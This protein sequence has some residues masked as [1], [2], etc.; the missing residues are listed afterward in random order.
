MADREG[1]AGRQGCF[2]LSCFG[3]LGAL[4]LFVIAAGG[5]A[6]LA[7]LMGPPPQE[8]V[9]PGIARRLPGP[10]Q[11]SGSV[12][13]DRGAGFPAG[14][15]RPP[16]PG[17]GRIVLDLSGGEFEVRPGEPG[18]PVRVD[19]RYN[20]GAFEIVE[21]LEPGDD[22]A[23]WTY[24]L[25]FRRHVSWMR[26]L[27]GDQH[28]VNHVRITLPRGVPF[29]LEGDVNVG[30]SRWELGGLW[31]LGANLQ[32]GTGEHTLGFAEPTTEP[33][34]RFELDSRMGTFVIE[35]LGNASPAKVMIRGSMGEMNLDLRGPWRN[36]T[37]VVGRWRMGAFSVRVPQDVRI[38]SDGATVFMGGADLSGLRRLAP[39]ADDA[40]TMRL[41]LSGAMG[42]LVV[43]P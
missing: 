20:A 33:I 8:F 40:R 10:P 12:S 13:S 9:E 14:E 35:R 31:L 19:G 6:L 24:R 2:K 22:G 15:F 29:V 18:G 25:R 17:P 39:P 42:E 16:G 36:D 37:E 28:E 38:E 21:A 3:C 4:G 41:D 43:Q 27:F 1:S 30:V 32:A 34:E 26:M 7:L 23:R 11:H 5:I